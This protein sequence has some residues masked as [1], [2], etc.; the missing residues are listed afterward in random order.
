MLRLGVLER[1]D[2]LNPSR[3]LYISVL[4]LGCKFVDKIPIKFP[5]IIAISY[6]WLTD[7]GEKIPLVL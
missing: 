4:L 7:K 1:F 6:K 2:N 5:R 3:Q